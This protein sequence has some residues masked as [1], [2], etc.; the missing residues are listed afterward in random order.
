MNVNN[1]FDEVID[2]F[3]NIINN[4]E[5]TDYTVRGWYNKQTRRV[6]LMP[7]EWS[8]NYEVEPWETRKAQGSVKVNR[9]GLRGRFSEDG[10]VLTGGLTGTAQLALDPLRTKTRSGLKL[11]HDYAT[12]NLPEG[13]GKWNTDNR[14]DFDR[15]SMPAP[16]DPPPCNPSVLYGD[17]A[18]EDNTE[19]QSADALAA[20]TSFWK[21]ASAI[22]D[23]I[24]GVCQQPTIA[25]EVSCRRDLL[26]IGA[27][28]PSRA[29]DY[30]QRVDAQENSFHALGGMQS[31]P[32]SYML[33]PSP[34]EEF[35]PVDAALDWISRG[36]YSGGEPEGQHNPFAKRLRNY[37]GAEWRIY[38]DTDTTRRVSP[39]PAD[40]DAEYLELPW[41]APVL[42]YNTFASSLA[43]DACSF[44]SG[45]VC[46][47]VLVLSREDTTCTEDSSDVASCSSQSGSSDAAPTFEQLDTVGAA[48]ESW[49]GAF[50]PTKEYKLSF[51]AAEVAAGNGRADMCAKVDGSSGSEAIWP[52]ATEVELR[53][54]LETV[55]PEFQPRNIG[56]RIRTPT[57]AEVVPEGIATVWEITL[58]LTRGHTLDLSLSWRS[59]GGELC[60]V[61]VSPADNHIGYVGHAGAYTHARKYRKLLFDNYEA[62]AHM[63]L[64]RGAVQELA[65]ASA[66]LFPARF[67]GK[68]YR[69]GGETANYAGNYWFAAAAGS[70][71]IHARL[72]ALRGGATC[73]STPDFCL[74][75]AMPIVPLPVCT[76]DTHGGLQWA[77][78]V[79]RPSVVGTDSADS[80]TESGIPRSQ[81]VPT[82]G[83]KRETK[84]FRFVVQLFASI[85]QDTPLWTPR[86]QE[87]RPGDVRFLWTTRRWLQVWMDI[88]ANNA[89]ETDF[90]LVDFV[91]NLRPGDSFIPNRWVK[92][93]LTEAF[94]EACGCNGA[95]AAGTGDAAEAGSEGGEEGSGDAAEAASSCEA[96]CQEDG[97]ELVMVPYFDVMDFFH[98]GVPS[99]CSR[100]ARVWTAVFDD[101]AEL[102]EAVAAYA[103]DETTTKALH[104]DIFT[105]DVSKVTNMDR[106]FC[107]A[108]GYCAGMDSVNFVNYATG[109]GSSWDISSWDV[110][111]VTTMKHM[112]Y[113][114]T[115]F[116]SDLS[117]WDVSSV[118]CMN[119]M[120]HTASAFN[121]DLSRWNVA[122]MR[123]AGNCDDGVAAAAYMFQAASALQ[124]DLRTWDLSG[125]TGLVVGSS[126]E[127]WLC[128]RNECMGTGD[129]FTASCSEYNT[130]PK[131]PTTPRG[132]VPDACDGAAAAFTAFAKPDAAV[133]ATWHDW[134]VDLYNHN[135]REGDDAYTLL[136]QLQDD[137][138]AATPFSEWAYDDVPPAFAER[139]SLLRALAGVGLPYDAELLNDGGGTLPDWVWLTWDASSILS[140]GFR[141]CGESF[142]LFSSPGN[143]QL[144]LHGY[145]SQLDITTAVCVGGMSTHAVRNFANVCRDTKLSRA[146]TDGLAL[147][148]VSEGVAF[149][150]AFTGARASSD[151]ALAL[152]DLHCD[153]G[154]VYTAWARRLTGKDGRAALLDSYNAWVRT[155]PAFM[156]V[157]GGH[158]FAESS[159]E[160]DVDF[161]S[162]LCR[163]RDSTDAVCGAGR[164]QL[165][166]VG[167]ASYGTDLGAQDFYACGQW[168]LPAT[169]S[170]PAALREWASGDVGY[171]NVR[172]RAGPLDTWVPA[173]AS[174]DVPADSPLFRHAT[175]DCVRMEML[176]S[177]SL[178]IPGAALF[179]RTTLDPADG[180][181]RLDLSGWILEFPWTNMFEGASGSPGTTA[182][183]LPAVTTADASAESAGASYSLSGMFAGASRLDI[184]SKC[185]FDGLDGNDFNAVPSV[186]T[187]GMFAQAVDIE[188]FAAECLLKIAQH[189]TDT[190]QMYAHSSNV[191]PVW[192]LC[193]GDTALVRL[194]SA[195][196]M[197]AHVGGED[198]DAPFAGVNMQD[199]VFGSENLDLSAM[200]AHSAFAGSVSGWDFAGVDTL[201]MDGMFR[202]AAEFTGAGIDSWDFGTAS[203]AAIASMVDFLRDSGAGELEELPPLLPCTFSPEAMRG[204]FGAPGLDWANVHL[205][206]SEH[207]EEA[208]L[209]R[210][211]LTQIQALFEGSDVDTSV[212]ACWLLVKS[213]AGGSQR[214]GAEFLALLSECNAAT[215]ERAVD[216]DND[217]L[218]WLNADGTLVSMPLQVL[219]TARVTTLSGLFGGVQR[220]AP[221]G[222]VRAWDVS[223]VSDFSYMF[224][225]SN[226]DDVDL[227]NWTIRSE[228]EVNFAHM[229]SGAEALRRPELFELPDGVEAN[230]SGMF[231]EALNFEGG[232]D[233]LCLWEGSLVD[234]SFMFAFTQGFPFGCGAL[235]WDVSAVG[236]MAYAFFY[237]GSESAKYLDL[238]GWDVGAVTDFSH[239][240]EGSS[241]IAA[242]LGEWEIGAASPVDI[243]YMFAGCALQRTHPLSISAAIG[244]ATCAFW[245]CSEMQFD[246]TGWTGGVV[247]GNWDGVFFNAVSFG[248]TSDGGAVLRNLTNPPSLELAFVGTAVM[249]REL[250][251]DFDA[252]GAVPRLLFTQNAADEGTQT[253]VSLTG[254]C[255]EGGACNQE[256]F[257]VCDLALPNLRFCNASYHSTPSGSAL[258]L[259]QDFADPADM[260]GVLCGGEPPASF[261]LAVP[262]G[263]RCNETALVACSKKA[264]CLG[265]NAGG[266]APAATSDPFDAGG[267]AFAKERTVMDAQDCKEH[268]GL[269]ALGTSAKCLVRH[270]G[271]LE[272]PVRFF[273]GAPA[274]LGAFLGE[275]C[276]GGRVF[277]R[278]TSFEVPPGA[279]CA[280]DT[281]QRAPLHGRRAAAYAGG[282]LA[283]C[284]N[285]AFACLGGSAPPIEAVDGYVLRRCANGGVCEWPGQLCL[286]RD[287]CF[288]GM[289]LGLRG[290]APAMLQFTAPGGASL[291]CAPPW[292]HA[293]TYCFNSE[294]LLLPPGMVLRPADGGGEAFRLPGQYAVHGDPCT[295]T[296]G[297]KLAVDAESGAHV[298]QLPC[299]GRQTYCTGGVEEPIP[300]GALLRMQIAEK[301]LKAAAAAGT[302]AAGCR[303]VEGPLQNVEVST[304]PLHDASACSSTELFTYCTRGAV[305]PIPAGFRKRGVTVRQCT[306]NECCVGGRYFAMACPDPDELWWGGVWYWAQQ[307]M[308]GPFVLVF[309]AAAAVLVLLLPCILYTCCVKRSAGGV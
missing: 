4:Q 35:T 57:S 186:D 92:T 118:T 235:V 241:R 116:N 233:K 117:R 195:K 43:L 157:Y 8:W 293:R 245:G 163:R 202:S 306:P 7:D 189:V 130:P 63:Q 240:F 52:S 155:T 94:N 260:G 179:S 231:F 216:V 39:A 236:S 74:P 141:S 49:A 296:P 271:E 243:S 134:Q 113:G 185:V 221:W 26:N 223:S 246:T 133:I 90:T 256:W 257:G 20:A 212:I 262:P 209:F 294:T 283:L 1:G 154:G 80:E 19:W 156:D 230:T 83:D 207:S 197:F 199:C 308:V 222:G 290:S 81:G 200:F 12:W 138:S 150:D 269:S 304:S 25:D 16:A 188:G 2:G 91:S 205:W 234:I 66:A 263:W 252:G 227:S 211:T 71:D 270:A 194:H 286:A 17:L 254:H 244:D 287:L 5:D 67:T 142:E 22:E 280:P 147:W 190:S 302:H 165:G 175:L 54:A 27:S 275:P 89:V 201:T 59:N 184:S 104:G 65:L 103:E 69:A 110:S 24:N 108:E 193:D 232:G 162:L 273:H 237:A 239:M 145:F 105:W 219:D 204:A 76:A 53:T 300:D 250:N 46:N 159:H 137:A 228:G 146:Q 34:G 177:L 75:D 88:G 47:D 139:V 125:M 259:R 164:Q 258:E 158:L 307:L 289:N 126:G 187:S 31:D 218:E 170:L 100:V 44:P 32:D 135:L 161:G 215:T 45:T 251:A 72:R 115:Q 203:P 131:C 102:R 305:A 210:F 95:E 248:T 101:T 97:L 217:A 30:K 129:V 182:V 11:V 132:G 60:D 99:D 268:A 40:P 84:F 208:C 58:F 36:A 226:V 160:M 301:A 29:D 50:R 173:G 309:C 282:V 266:A 297:F 128:Q 298:G 178:Q 279:R 98:L 291:P 122:A 153:I 213:S 264:P 148:D 180:A 144:S 288:G 120:F 114:N 109:V 172:L 6:E 85:V 224:A 166:R 136:F 119:H 277:S 111:G 124:T 284:T 299:T 292:T 143:E 278:G 168:L 18:C 21:S 281:A 42:Q 255:Q 225:R 86:R 33:V 151:D 28:P 41:N 93:Q 87:R 249:L 51:T 64:H 196:Q 38:D 106:L 82:T 3:P 107:G 73:D 238:G 127:D 191:S 48:F 149:D 253:F 10:L 174:V 169:W 276:T 214:E 62:L 181:C 295:A 242:K 303:G 78:R 56:I 77:T 112:F 14:N 79:A 247:G 229:F 23:A 96:A 15:F 9:I 183:T 70:A 140:G 121:S 152:E 267:G 206:V 198:G 274:D 171:E 265:G 123:S 167:A 285:P 55:L 272:V 192:N 37:I 220:T 61:E 261:A 13:G 176:S 68:F